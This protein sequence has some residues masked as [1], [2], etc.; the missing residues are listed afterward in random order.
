MRECFLT[1]AK[2]DLDKKLWK[3]YR[4]PLTFVVWMVLRDRSKS[5]QQPSKVT[6]KGGMDLVML[7]SARTK[8]RK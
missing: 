2:N 5:S 3:V 1:P 8:G 6:V 7:I 4:G